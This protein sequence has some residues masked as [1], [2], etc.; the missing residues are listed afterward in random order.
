MYLLLFGVSY[1]DDSRLLRCHV[2]WASFGGPQCLLLRGK[3]DEGTTIPR[4]VGH[5]HNPEGFKFWQLRCV[6]Q[7]EIWSCQHPSLCRA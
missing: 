3:Q 1:L 4:N 6:D 7:P 5:C 2:R